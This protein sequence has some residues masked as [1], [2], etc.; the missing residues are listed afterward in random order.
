MKKEPP[1]SELLNSGFFRFKQ[2]HLDRSNGCYTMYGASVVKISSI[3]FSEWM[4]KSIGLDRSRLK[5]PM[6]DLA[7]IT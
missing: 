1:Q 2:N 7:S 6:M 4:F 3:W 5:I